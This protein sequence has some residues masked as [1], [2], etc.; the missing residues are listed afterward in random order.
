MF[1]SILY[2]ENYGVRGKKEKERER[3]KKFT[4]GDSSIESSSSAFYNYFLLF[5]ISSASYA[6]SSTA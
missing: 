4:Q 3:K 1:K 2:K 6:V 5:K